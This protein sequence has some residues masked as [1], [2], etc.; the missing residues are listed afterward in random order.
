MNITHIPKEITGMTN[1]QLSDP[2]KLHNAPAKV[3]LPSQC[4]GAVGGW[5]VG[6]GGERGGGRGGGR[7]EECLPYA[8]PLCAWPS[9]ASSCMLSEAAADSP[10]RSI[11]E[12]LSMVAVSPVSSMVDPLGLSTA[13][14]GLVCTPIGGS[15]GFCASFCSCE[16]LPE[17][18]RRPLP[19]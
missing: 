17:G 18:R 2:Q 12:F 15:Q 5:E 16:V 1:F 10:V 7:G 8:G 6:G 14:A 9:S 4:N 13:S 19:G 3:A 11:T